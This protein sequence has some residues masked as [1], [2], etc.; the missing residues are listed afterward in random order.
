MSGER[1]IAAMMAVPLRDAWARVVVALDLLGAA[2]E[3]DDWE[4][5]AE[6]NRQLQ[7]CLERFDAVLADHR[8]GLSPDHVLSLIAALKA[9]FERH[10]R[11]MTA[12][13]G[14]RDAI[15]EELATAR[16]GHTAA[17]HYLEAA[18]A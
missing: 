16:D 4:G 15:A 8:D 9:V 18:G 5:A 13:Q 6:G 1:G 2:V 11:H 12:L 3:A 7:A 10:A 17:R 14:A